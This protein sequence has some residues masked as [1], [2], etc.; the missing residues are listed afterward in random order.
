MKL[1]SYRVFFAALVSVAGA[2]RDG[3][4]VRTQQGDVIGTLVTPSVRQFL[5]IPYAVANRWEAPK[6]PPTRRAPF[7]ATS[8]GDS[9][10]Q[11]LNAGNLEFLKLAGIPN[12]TVPESEDCLS[13]NIWAPSI[14]R[15]QGTA[16]MLWIYGGGFQF[17]T[18]CAS[19]LLISNIV[20]YNG[21]NL[22]RDQDDVLL[23]TF[24]YRLNIFGQPNAPQLAN[25]TTSQNFGLLDLDAA[26]KWV[27]DNIA[28]FGGDPER[29]TLFGQSA[30]SVAADA[31][32]FA[33]PNDTMVK[34][35]I[36]QS[37]NLA[38]VGASAN[39]TLDPTSWNAIASAVGCGTTNNAAQLACMKAVPF[40]KLEDTIINTNAAFGLVPDNINIFTDTT[41][42]AAAGNFLKVPLLGGSTQHEG[43]VFVV[44][45]EEVAAGVSLPVITEL[46][47]DIETQLGFT[48]PASKAASDRTTAG[49]PTWR[50]QYQAIFPDI[51]T[52]PDL[53]AYHASEIP[54][55]FGTYNSSLGP[56]PT[57]AEVTLSKYV[58][59]AW[60]A[61]ARNPAQGLRNFGWPVY[62]PNAA[63]LVQLGGF[64]NQTGATF[65]PPA[66]LDFTCGPAASATLAGVSAQLTGL[67]GA[68]G[69]AN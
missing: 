32:T 13:V 1:Y 7:R 59:S 53:R 36:E 28:A 16:V 68:T 54:I 8:F 40:R 62:D 44:G 37:G 50:Y 29:I 47:A 46:L 2:Q 25:G 5:G 23:V 4:T 10:L 19:A 49:V 26:V 61:F 55:V 3:L 65:A 51:S 69:S 56:P 12:A 34:G 35:V 27:H 38:I 64:F 24:N 63:T 33:H 48:C 20:V 22:V 18:A 21:Q 43:D 15:K 39:A 66:L 52:R 42:R 9:C 6:Q 57:A 60:V 11:A 17:G 30:G 58:Q 31:Y 14:R 45:A 67:L 41:S